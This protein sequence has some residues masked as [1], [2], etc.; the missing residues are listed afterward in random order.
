MKSALSN[1]AC[2]Q[3]L[4]QGIYIYISGTENQWFHHSRVVY[5]FYSYT[6]FDLKCYNEVVGKSSVDFSGLWVKS[7]GPRP[8][9]NLKETFHMFRYTLYLKGFIG[10][11]LPKVIL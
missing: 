5:T 11:R 3:V 4:S 1:T 2:Q 8:T 9:K 6:K 7:F 10:C